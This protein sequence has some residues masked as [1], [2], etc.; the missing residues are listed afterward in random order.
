LEDVAAAAR[1]ELPF[2]E[3]MESPPYL[4]VFANPAEYKR[5]PVR[6]ANAIGQTA[7]EAES[8]GRTTAGVAGSTWSEERGTLRP[9][10]THEYIHALLERAGRLPNRGDWLHE[11]LATHYQQRFHPQAGLAESI[12]A[13]LDQGWPLERL[14]DGKETPQEQYWQALSF[15]DYLLAVRPKEFAA[16]VVALRDAGST[17]VGPHL[18]TVMQTDW[19]TLTADW[20][21]YWMK[22]R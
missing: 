20:K 7:D 1:K 19:P 6:L 21:A 5:F 14:C 18:V 10:Y 3:E 8:S 9:V 12:R 15:V 11:G 17:N 16:L 22:Q 2:L 13:G 4:N